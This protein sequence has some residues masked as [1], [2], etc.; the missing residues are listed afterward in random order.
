MG[1]FYPTSFDLETGTLTRPFNVDDFKNA[2]SS[3]N[4]GELNDYAN[5]YK[6]NVY[7]ANNYFQDIFVNSV[8]GLSSNILEFLS[9]ITENVQDA[10]NYLGIIT[11]NIDY[12]ATNN[13]TKIEAST[14]TDSIT[15]TSINAK[16]MTSINCQTQSLVT[17]KIV[18]N[19]IMTR[20]IRCDEIIAKNTQPVGA[21][22]FLENGRTI[23]IIKT[24]VIT[25]SMPSLVSLPGKS[26]EVTLLPGYRI[27]FL[28]SLGNLIFSVDNTD[29]EAMLYGKIIRFPVLPYKYTLFY[30]GKLIL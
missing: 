21:Y 17:N 25:T 27:N 19:R 18:S 11:V 28:D 23:P 14:Y 3:V 1:D 15:S 8:N 4:K 13:V 26:C 9:T 20:T 12:D 22:I 29:A 10:L 7:R 5:K 30:L 2:Y 24:G 6:S 16:K